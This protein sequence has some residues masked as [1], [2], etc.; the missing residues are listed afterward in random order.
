MM[1]NKIE[2]TKKPEINKAINK[3]LKKINSDK[4]VNK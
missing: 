3:K 4:K 2:K 1:K